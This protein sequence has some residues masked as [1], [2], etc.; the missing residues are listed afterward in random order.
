MMERPM[1]KTSFNI[2]VLLLRSSLK[3]LQT[4]MAS[5]NSFVSEQFFIRKQTVNLNGEHPPNTKNASDNKELVQ[6]F[7]EH[8]LFKRENRPQRQYYL[9]VK[10]SWKAISKKKVDQK[11]DQKVSNNNNNSLKN[12]FQT[13]THRFLR[14]YQLKIILILITP[15][16]R[17]IVNITLMIYLFQIPPKRHSIKISEQLRSIRVE[18]YSRHM[19]SKKKT[20]VAL[21][22]LVL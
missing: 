20:K 5:S 9:T 3:E 1:A 16:L 12:Q 17:L 13:Q 10:E 19:E 2:T 22:L 6:K 7:S 15:T 14:V 8:R 4:E 21:N 11:V 18:N